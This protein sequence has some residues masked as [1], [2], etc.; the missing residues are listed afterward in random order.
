VKLDKKELT[1]TIEEYN[2]K[3]EAF[4]FDYFKSNGIS[5]S[6]NLNKLSVPMLLKMNENYF[7]PEKPT[8]IIFG[9]ETNIWGVENHS[10]YFDIRD[11]TEETI[12]SVMGHYEWQLNRLKSKSTLITL[13][14]AIK[15]KLG[16]KYNILW[17]N[18][19]K[20]SYGG[21]RLYGSRT[22]NVSKE[23]FKNIMK[24]QKSFMKFELEL[25]QPQGMI[26][27]T[28]KGLDTEIEYNLNSK[29]ERVENYGD[30]CS[31]LNI[32]SDFDIDENIKTFRAPHPDWCRYRKDIN[33][34]NVIE[35]LTEVFG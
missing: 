31:R 35:Y 17:S 24:H 15:E 8:I 26:F 25:L 11:N 2:Q 9:Q 30:H 22:K 3:L 29:V 4:Y 13:N 23:H 34:K 6:T 28:G 21:K 18:L 7:N 1:M 10:T 32:R 14:I 12:K 20:Y 27:L 5:D 16:Y 33:Q 19:Y